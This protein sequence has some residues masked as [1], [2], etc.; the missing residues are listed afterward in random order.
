MNMAE[1]LARNAQRFPGKPALIDERRRL[2]PSGLPFAHQP[3]G[4][5]PFEAGRFQRA[6]ASPYPAGTAPSISK[7]SLPWP[8]SAPSPFPSI[9]VGAS[10]SM[11]R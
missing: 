11:T 1:A 10:M 8:R 4:E 7:R 9:M 2:T 3:V 5:L 6:T